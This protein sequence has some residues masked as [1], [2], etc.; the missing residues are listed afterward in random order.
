MRPLETSI[1]PVEYIFMS[2]YNSLSGYKFTCYK[3]CARKFYLSFAWRLIYIKC[4]YLIHLRIINMY[5]VLLYYCNKYIRTF[6]YSLFS[7]NQF[8]IVAYYFANK[9]HVIYCVLYY[10]YISCVY[11]CPR[12]LQCNMY[13]DFQFKAR[14]FLISY[15]LSLCTI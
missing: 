2:L 10:T 13:F 14:I 9:Q 12:P 4:N 6:S 5:C 11:P 1:S 15:M 7:E 3:H 8:S